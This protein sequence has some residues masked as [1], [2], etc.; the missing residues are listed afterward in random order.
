MRYV[1]DPNEQFHKDAKKI[2]D[3]ELEKSMGN[4]IAAIDTSEANFAKKGH[5]YD[6]ILCSF[7]EGSNGIISSWDDQ[8]K[9]D[10]AL[11]I[12]GVGGGSRKAITHCW[13]TG[14]TFYA[15]DTGYLGNVK[16]K[17]WHRITKNNLQN[18]EPIQERNDDRLKRLN[19]HYK[20]FTPGK[21]ILICPPSA[22]VMDLWKQP[23]P[24]EWT[25][26]V[27]EELKKYTDRPVEIRLKPLRSERITTKTI[28]AALQDD[29]HCLITYNSIA[30]TEA[31][32]NG[33]PAIAL[34]PNAAQV[35]CN[36]KL[37]DVENL[38]IP[39]QDEMYA[40]V[41]HLSYCQFT[42][43]EMRSGYAWDIVNENS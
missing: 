17:I 33:K 15:V 24:E 9:S 32:L 42:E 13:D 6:P 41:K 14:R 38:N 2:F 29:V 40:F 21:K 39:T 8:E 18:L 28:E 35:L 37:S 30:A 4:K 3:E 25:N 43:D 31:L 20:S 36:K 7:I 11:V 10:Y 34:G 5:D 23:S 1:I 12:R 19:Y 26:R 16:S 22:K 27:I